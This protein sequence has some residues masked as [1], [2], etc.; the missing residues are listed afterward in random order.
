MV[1]QVWRG[2]F[3]P[4]ILATPRPYRELWTSCGFSICESP[5]LG[6]MSNGELEC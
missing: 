1:P 3:V 4:H 2:G 6:D 5:S